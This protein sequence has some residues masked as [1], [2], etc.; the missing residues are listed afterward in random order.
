MNKNTPLN[1]LLRQVLPVLFLA[2]A[3]PALSVEIPDTPDGTVT[4]VAGALADHHPEVLWQALPPSYQSDITELTRA[5]AARMDSG[6]WDAAF[7]LGRKL[8]GILKDKK[9]II[10]DS[11]M[12]Q[13]AGEE[14][15][16]IE[17]NW[18]SMVDVLAGFCSS[19]VSRLE[20][21][22]TIDWERFLAT[23][24]RDLMNRAAEASKASDDDAYDREFKQK[25]R[26]TKVEVVSVEGDQ[27]TL[28]LSAP[29]EDPEEM[30]LIRVEGRW[31]PS[32]MVADWEADVAEA[33]QKLATI[34]DEEIQQGSMQAMMVIGMVDG[35]LT[36]L[37]SVES[38][39][40]LEQAIQGLLGPLLGGAMGAMP[41]EEET[42]PEPIE[43]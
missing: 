11:S 35:V 42:E 12:L 7:G 43:S 37:E 32:E 31:V 14:H 27:A 23:T 19:D 2:V 6:V 33:K 17:D 4:A 18:D 16:R 39:E 8:A 13:S 5:F 34:T 28:R 36:Q 3:A 38:T 1:R 26:Q 20:S 29:D 40:E 41:E 15:Q 22:E 21:L 30:Q 10:L 25:L 9:A 24:G